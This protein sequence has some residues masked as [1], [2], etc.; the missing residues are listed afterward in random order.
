MQGVN[1]PARQNKGS[2]LVQFHLPAEVMP[3]STP[4]VAV[5]GSSPAD[6]EA[7]TQADRER[8]REGGRRGPEYAVD[9]GTCPAV[10]SP[11]QVYW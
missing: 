4:G 9:G 7:S 5:M 11:A 6:T 1:R 10:A 2:T 3:S 8:E